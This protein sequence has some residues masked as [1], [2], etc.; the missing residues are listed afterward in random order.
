MIIHDIE[1][2]FMPMSLFRFDSFT[3]ITSFVPKGKSVI[4]WKV[5]G[6][7]V[8]YKQIK[9]AVL[10]YIDADKWRLAGAKA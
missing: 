4:K 6:K 5:N 9:N 8:S 3:P 1:C 10:I 2:V 7:Q